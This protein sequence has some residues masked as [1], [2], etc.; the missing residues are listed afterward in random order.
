MR[1]DSVARPP[2]NNVTMLSLKSSKAVSINSARHFHSSISISPGTLRIRAYGRHTNR[3]SVCEGMDRLG[4]HIRNIRFGTC[5]TARNGG[6]R[7]DAH[8]MAATQCSQAAWRGLRW[9]LVP[10]LEVS[11]VRALAQV[12]GWQAG[13]EQESGGVV[14]GGGF[15]AAR[16]CKCRRS[17]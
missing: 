2:L 14:G 15:P 13:G 4:V 3:N 8:S 9:S 10:M 11:C 12:S 1:I 7:A 17:G 5:L 6:Y 16:W